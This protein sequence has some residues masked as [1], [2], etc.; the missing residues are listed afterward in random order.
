MRWAMN[1]HTRGAAQNRDSARNLLA[2]LSP[3]FVRRNNWDDV[4]EFGLVFSPKDIRSARYR[5]NY[6]SLKDFFAEAGIVVAQEITGER[7]C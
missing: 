5:E 4:S 2:L 7:T 6:Q 1:Q 3:L